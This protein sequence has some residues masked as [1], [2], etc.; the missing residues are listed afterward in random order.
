M[1][2]T[3]SISEL[4]Y[5]CTSRREIDPQEIRHLAIAASA[6]LVALTELLSAYERIGPVDVE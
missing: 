2:K 5:L 3:K 6:E 1:I 4:L